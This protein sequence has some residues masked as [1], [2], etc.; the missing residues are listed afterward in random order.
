MSIYPMQGDKGV[1]F[2]LNRVH[3]RANNVDKVLTDAFKQV[4]QE[5]EA[6][7]IVEINVNVHGHIKG[8]SMAGLYKAAHPKD[9]S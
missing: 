7:G 8:L 9:V 4:R 2:Q 3:A 6:A 5:T 1:S